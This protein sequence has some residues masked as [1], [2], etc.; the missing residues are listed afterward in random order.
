MARDFSYTFELAGALAGSFTTSF[1][2]ANLA[3]EQSSQ[4]VNKLQNKLEELEKAYQNGTIKT[5]QYE[6]QHKKLS[7]ALEQETNNFTSLQEQLSSTNRIFDALSDVA[8]PY[9]SLSGAMATAGLGATI[10]VNDLDTLM[11]ATKNLQSST[12]A[13]DEELS[14][15]KD[16]MLDIYASGFGTSFEDIGAVMGSVKQVIGQTGEEL[17]NASKGAILMRDT[18][19]IEVNESVRAADSLMKHFGITGNEAYTLIAQGAQ[20]GANKN[21]DLADSLNEYAV[22]FAQLGFSAEEFTGILINGAQTGAFSVD[23]VGDA[24][25][26][27]GIRVRESSNTTAEG[28]GFI[29]LDLDEMQAKFAQGGKVAQNAFKETLTAILS[30]EDPIKRNTAGVDLLGTMWEDL[31]EKGVRELLNISQKA[32]MSANTLEKIQLNNLS[33]IG[34]VFTLIGR[35]LEVGLLAPLNS[36]ALPILKDFAGFILDNMD[37]IQAIALPA[38]AGISAGLIAFAGISLAPIIASIG[39]F[40]VTV[41][42]IPLAIAGI[43]TVAVYLYQN[44]DSV[45]NYLSE[46]TAG[47]FNYIDEIINNFSLTI[48]RTLVFVQGGFTNLASYAVNTWNNFTQNISS[49]WNDLTGFVLQGI[50]TLIA[51]IINF[52]NTL[53]Y[54]FGYVIGFISTLPDRIVSLSTNIINFLINL[55]NMYFNL[56]MNL[57]TA[58][59]NFATNSINTITTTVINIGSFL[60]NLPTFALNA[61]IAFNANFQTYLSLAYNIAVTNMSNLV[62]G[63]YSFLINLPNMVITIGVDIV[64]AMSEW[65]M[66]AYN[67][68]A[69]AINQIPDLVNTALNNAKN[70]VTNFFDGISGNFSI[71][72]EAGSSVKEN[73]LGGIYPKG[74]FL[75][76]FA[77]K[78]AEAAI[79]I[80]GSTRAINL[81]KQTGK[82]LGVYNENISPQFSEPSALNLNALAYPNLLTENIPKE[83]SSYNNI[84]FSPI[85]DAKPIVINNTDNISSLDTFSSLADV[86]SDFENPNNENIF[87]QASKY[88]D[89]KNNTT[90][91]NNNINKEDNSIQIN[92]SPKIYVQGSQQNNATNDVATTLISLLRQELPRILKDIDYDKKRISFNN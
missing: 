65:A 11:V 17:E 7:I 22:H 1:N 55:P 46:K 64:N 40:V 62:M 25:K 84:D 16:T 32:D 63:V 50:D 28:F 74:A 12:G 35:N 69:N 73:Y 3:V 81:W 15:M 59:V 19:N 2:S 61:L 48:D 85:Q 56:M 14:S 23:K 36:A 71:G 31:G 27:F 24:M 52:P 41:G 6:L 10:L 87:K 86:F 4:R 49:L 45:M 75:T 43:V 70:Y 80:D 44:W 34:D 89:R 42:A 8:A 26:E 67:S 92:I 82:L 37:L 88:F 72:F 77:E 57:S 79:P 78:S 51:G 20:N 83:I 68:V 66:G 39:A 47:I 76:T 30:V 53:A 5:K 9:V 33:S 18:F 21:G 54:A 13:T 90:N 29:G 58:T 60:M 38:I 91:N